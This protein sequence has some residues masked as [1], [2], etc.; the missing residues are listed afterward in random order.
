LLF[1]FQ[2]LGLTLLAAAQGVNIGLTARRSI[3]TSVV[4]A[5]GMTLLFL[6]M[7]SLSGALIAPTYRTI[8]YDRSIRTVIAVLAASV[9]MTL[10]TT[11]LPFVITMRAWNRTRTSPR[12]DVLPG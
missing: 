12:A 3:T 5:G 8:S 6:I 7:F 4:L 2:I 11:V 9:G 10:V 1:P